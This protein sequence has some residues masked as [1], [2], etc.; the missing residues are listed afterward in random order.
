M[1]TTAP[2]MLW[3][4][5]ASATAA[6]IAASDSTPSSAGPGAAV[7]DEADADAGAASA[8]EAEEGMGPDAAG[9]RRRAGLH[10]ASATAPIAGA[11]RRQDPLR[12]KSS[13]AVVTSLVHYVFRLRRQRQDLLG[14][15]QAAATVSVLVE[16]QLE[17]RVDAGRHP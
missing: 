16:E 6:S 9:V 5:M 3:L 11:N 15:H 7:F 2:G 1:R 13:Y 12:T 10:I 4:A 17:T 8:P 14:C